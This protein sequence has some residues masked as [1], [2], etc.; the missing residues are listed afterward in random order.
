MGGERKRGRKILCKRRK[1]LPTEVDL[2]PE[3]WREVMVRLPAKTLVR[4]R[5]VCK[6]WCSMIDEPD[7]LSM[8]LSVY[9]NNVDKNR[10]LVMEYSKSRYLFGF[11]LNS[12]STSTTQFWS[13][14][15]LPLGHCNGLVLLKERDSTSDAYELFSGPHPSYKKLFYNKKREDVKGLTPNFVTFAIRS[16]YLR[17]FK[18][19]LR[20]ST[21]LTDTGS[22]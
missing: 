16:S 5:S 17:S 7:F 10:L 21:E 2:P 12:K 9:K 4:F 13:T 8:H 18:W 11:R 20:R 15:F 6:A 3:L 22:Y 1:L 19:L 14:T